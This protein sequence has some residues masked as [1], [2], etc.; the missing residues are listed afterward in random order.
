[1]SV[2]FILNGEQKV[3]YEDLHQWKKDPQ[4]V[5]E[6]FACAVQQVRN[7][8]HEPVSP[9]DNGLGWEDQWRDHMAVDIAMLLQCDGI[10]LLP[11]W[12]LSVGARIEANIA[13]ECDMT[14]IRQTETTALRG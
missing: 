1:M 5:R 6:K 7:M 11:D 10:Y 14:I 12:H 2:G 8:G 9:L 13:A 3:R 4:A